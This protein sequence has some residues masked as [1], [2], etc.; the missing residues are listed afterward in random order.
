MIVC[1]PVTVAD[2]VG[3]GFG[4]ASLVAIADVAGGRVA[5]WEV[6]DVGWG[7]LHDAGTEGTHHARIA[8]FVREHRV[9]AVVGS[10]MGEGMLRMLGRMNV[11]V[12]LGASGDARAAVLQV[13]RDANAANPDVN[14]KS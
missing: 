2:E 6:F 5:S 4:R 12:H 8:A 14:P 3:P 11:D 1:I 13:I 7:D 9:E 10:H